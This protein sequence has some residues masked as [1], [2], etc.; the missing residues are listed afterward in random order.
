LLTHQYTPENFSAE[1]L[2]GH[3]KPRA[4]ALLAAAATI[5]FEN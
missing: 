1:T 3:D 2:K 4:E 5:P